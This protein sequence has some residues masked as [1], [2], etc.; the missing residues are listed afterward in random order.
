MKKTIA[1]SLIVFSILCF[2]GIGHA[3]EMKKLGVG[4]GV[5][6]L[7]Y[8]PATVVDVEFKMERTPVYNLNLTYHITPAWSLEGGA[9]A[10]QSDMTVSL[11]DYAGTLGELQQISFYLN[12]RYRFRI[13]RTRAFLHLGGGASYYLNE[14]ET[15]IPEEPDDFYPLNIIAE[16]ENSFG[17]QLNVGAEYFFTPNYVVSLDLK[18]VFNTVEFSF[19]YPDATVEFEDV[20]LNGAA[21]MLGFKYYF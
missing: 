20:A 6:Y 3:E 10:R 4:L 15:N 9:E 21:Y 17:V 19:T 12:G 1:G 5:A 13:A 14:F 18:A 8:E 2:C 7:D 11:E 16:T